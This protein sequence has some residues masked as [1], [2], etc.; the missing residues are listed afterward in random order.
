MYKTDQRKNE[1]LNMLISCESLSVHEIVQ[2]LGVSLPTARRLCAGLADENKVVRVHGGIKRL[3]THDA[4]YSFDSLRN[5]HIEEKTAIAKYASTLVQNNQVIFLEAG[6][7]LR[8]FALALAERIRNQELSNVLIF[9]NSL[10]NLDILYPIQSNIQLIGGQYRDERKDFIGYISELALKGLRFHYCFMGAD[11]VSL[12]DGAMAMDMDTVRFDTQL[13]THAEKTVILAHSEKFEKH[14]LISYIPLH[15][16]HTIIT[17]Q[18]LDASIAA[19]YRE[20]NIPLVM[21]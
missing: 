3:P 10:I 18:G 2:K 1:V 11:A 4:I 17:D 5:E 7:T 13:V 12:G 19:D 6:T 16:V 21:V 9:T 20:R 8:L 15:K 14:S